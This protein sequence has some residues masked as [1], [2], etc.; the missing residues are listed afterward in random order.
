MRM[1]MRMRRKNLRRLRRLCRI[2]V[3]RT[4]RDVGP[5]AEVTEKNIQHSTFNIQRPRGSAV[6]TSRA[7]GCLALPRTTSTGGSSNSG[8][9]PAPRPRNTRRLFPLNPPRGWSRCSRS[10]TTWFSIRSAA[11]PRFSHAQLQ[12]EWKPHTT[13]ETAFAERIRSKISGDKIRATH[14]SH[15]KEITKP[16]RGNNWQSSKRLSQNLV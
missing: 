4:Q 15:Q 14:G 8:S 7:G 3:Q 10:P 12:I 1:R 5:G 11:R 16:A 6:R 2:V 13:A 9:S